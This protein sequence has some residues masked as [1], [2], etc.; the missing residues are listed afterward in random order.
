MRAL[1]LG[2]LFVIV[3]PAGAEEGY[4]SR[5]VTFIVP[6]GPGSGNDVIA[7]ILANK[8]SANWR[9][10]VVV[11]NRPGATGGVALE[12]TAKAAPDGYTIVIGS[13]SQ[14]INQHLS[15]MRYDMVT[16]FTPVTISGSLPFGVAVLGT[17]LAKTLTELVAV[18]KARPGK[19]NYTGTIGSIAQF[20]GE[21][22]KSAGNV[23]IVMI[24][25]KLGTDAEADVLA[26][27]VEVKTAS[28]T[29]GGL[30]IS[31]STNS[32]WFV[33]ALPMFFCYG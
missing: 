1:C 29:T 25:S 33:R 7:R 30:R 32:A 17:F 21:M 24:P 5:P 12:A 20:I 18:A 15:K 26:G 4:P 11:V 8:V 10:T 9:S 19:L 14:I 13:T 16:D 6:Y 2:V 22:L 3:G 28:S 23:D 31:G 27:R